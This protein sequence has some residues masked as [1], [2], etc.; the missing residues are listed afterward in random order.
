MSNVK[1]D[2]MKEIETKVARKKALAQQVS[3][4]KTIA[5]L[6]ADFFTEYEKVRKMDSGSFYANFEMLVI[7]S[8]RAKMS[9]IDRK[10]VVNFRKP[11]DGSNP[12]VEIKWSQSFVQT[13]NC[14]ETLVLDA[15]S[16]FFQ[17]MI[18]DT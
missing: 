8:L 7:Q 18:D 1:R 5:T 3:R 16:A 17:S 10:C 4:Q 14:E 2:L 9:N 6:V 11:E 15:S 13:N 12:V